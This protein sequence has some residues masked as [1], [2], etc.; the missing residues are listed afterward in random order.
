MCGSVSACLRERKKARECQ[1]RVLKQCRANRLIAAVPC[2]CAPTLNVLRRLW[3]QAHERSLQPCSVPT[4]QRTYR[5]KSRSTRIRAGRLLDG[6][7][8][9]QNWPSSQRAQLHEAV[10]CAWKA[11]ERPMDTN[12]PTKQPAEMA[13]EVTGPYLDCSVGM[14]VEGAC[15]QMVLMRWPCG[16]ARDAGCALQCLVRA[17]RQ[18][19]GATP[20]RA[21]PVCTR[22]RAT[23][24]LGGCAPA[25]LPAGR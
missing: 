14:S 15:M 7:R 5:I 18:P 12:D 20:A 10:Q 1:A 8:Q 9:L 6:P 4:A 3:A 11:A 2:A 13:K 16:A 17:C 25:W 21:R 24:G 22:R 19:A 23:C